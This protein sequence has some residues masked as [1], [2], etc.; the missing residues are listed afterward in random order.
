MREHFK[1]HNGLKEAQEHAIS[2][3]GEC[4]SKEYINGRTKLQW[5]C[6]IPEH[7]IWEATHSKVLK[8]SN[9]CPQ[10]QENRNIQEFR[11]R[12]ILNYLFDT[13]FV[14]T[15]KLEW[16]KNPQTGNFL[17][18]D[19][20]SE[21]LK[22]AFE[23][24]GQQHYDNIFRKEQLAYDTQEIRDLLKRENCGNKGVKLITIHKIHKKHVNDYELI[25]Q[26]ILSSIEESS[27]QLNK[28]INMEVI[29]E[30]FKLS[31]KNKHTISFLKKAKD[32]AVSRG[33]E[34]VSNEYV[35]LNTE[36]K[37]KCMN[38]VH[39]IWG[40]SF[41]R[42]VSN[43]TWCPECLS[44]KRTLLTR[45]SKGLEKAKMVALGHNG[46]CLS[47]EYLGSNYKLKWKCNNSKHA[48]W[49]ATYGSVVTGGSWCMLCYKE[50]RLKAKKEQQDE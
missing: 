37:W 32:Y 50:S 36:M 39:S 44:K 22:V 11:V 10:C 8:S 41:E 33:G 45:D 1:N 35:N 21:K 13:E 16:N 28:V 19:G 23:Y 24:Q 26:N 12:K 20:Y 2:K 7:A 31:P 25:L 17:E 29:R 15:R 27:I 40:K 38:S 30:I 3:G 48:E 34:C 43:K 6:N 47:D 49:E 42:I 14:K 4:L 46:K 9:W 18:L 5:K